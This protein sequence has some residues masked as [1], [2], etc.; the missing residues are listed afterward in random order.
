MIE[1]N[2]LSASFVVVTF[3]VKRFNLAFHASFDNMFE[4]P[5]SIIC[6]PAVLA[7]WNRPSFDPSIKTG[8]TEF[9]SFMTFVQMVQINLSS[10]ASTK[11]KSRSISSMNPTTLFKIAIASIFNLSTQLTD[12][13]GMNLLSLA[14]YLK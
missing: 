8:G 11:S 4:W 7:S 14:V 13:Y 2:K 5:L 6:S 12:F 10:I 3:Y 1:K 9:G